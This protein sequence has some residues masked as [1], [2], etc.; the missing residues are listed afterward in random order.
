MD[1]DARG[2]DDAAEPEAV[3][4]DDAEEEA[5]RRRARRAARRRAREAM[6]QIALANAANA[7]K[8][9]AE[10]PTADDLI[11]GRAEPREEARKAG[12]DEEGSTREEASEGDRPGEESEDPAS[13]S[14][15]R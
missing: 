1:E 14:A 11:E 9:A 8:E 7:A 4:A 3:V 2:A 13:K 15:A 10:N 12:P 6:E 5:K